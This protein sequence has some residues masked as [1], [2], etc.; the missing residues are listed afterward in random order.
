MVSLVA[1]AAAIGSSA[2][3]QQ[4][5]PPSSAAQTIEEVVVTAQKRSENVQN[6]PIAITAFTAQA[7]KEK[8]VQ[9]VHDL[10]ALTP[11]VNLD[12]SSPFSGSSVVLSASI[13]GIGQDDFAM[14]LDPGV[15]VYLDGVYLA[16]TVGA[17][18][19]LPDVE[20][21]EIA[22]G[23]QGTLFGRNTIGGAIS[24][25][26]HAPSDHYAFNGSATF[27]SYNRRDFQGIVD[28]PVNDSLRT[29]FTFSSE[30]RDGWQHVI[31]YPGLSG[32]RSDGNL[33]KSAGSQTS[34]TNGGQNQ[35]SI[36]G[37][38]LWLASD[39]LTVTLTADWTHVDQ[40]ATPNTALSTTE[41]V[42]GTLANLYDTCV[43]L[44]S[45]FLAGIGLGHVCNEPVANSG[46]IFSD[47]THPAYNSTIAGVGLPIDKTYANGNSF[48]KMD[49]YGGSLTI[50][51][52]LGENLNLKSIT[53]YRGLN[54]KAGLDDDGSP[55]SIIE[56]SFKE[57]QRQI[58]QEEQLTGE[59]FDGRLKYVG[60]LYYFNEHGYIHD[61]VVFDEGLLQINGP[62]T[63]DSSSYAAYT[64]MDYRLTD[65]IGLTLGA[66]YSLEEKEFI[67]GQ[68]DENGLAYKASG[69]Y[70]PG[71]SAAL[72]G[73]PANLTCQEAL[74]FPV[75]GQPLRYFPNT[76]N[77][78]DFRIF[79][80]AAGIQ[81]HFDGDRMAYF[82]YSKG[83]KSG[84]WTTRLSSPIPDASLAA[85]GPENA[86][87]Y[88]IGLKSKWLDRRLL[89]N[90][91]AFYTDYT[92]IQ[93]NFQQGISPT[94]KNA[95][96]AQIPGF[97]AETRWILGHGFSIG[98]SVGY[99]DAKYTKLAAGINGT[100]NCAIEACIDT[101][102]KL[103]K[104]PKWK[105]S[106]NPEYSYP[107]A[108]DASLRLGLDWNHTSSIF[109]NSVNSPI[110]RRPTVDVI[111]LQ[112]SYVAPGGR[113]EFTV[114]G[115]NITDQRYLV[116]GNCNTTGG[117]CS[118]TYNDPGEWYLRVRYRFDS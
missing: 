94:L 52:R 45:T 47:G 16:R 104:T 51:Y 20:R 107:L 11:N 118:G 43:S 15:G 80:P 115:T 28:I 73:A 30:Q 24:V 67:G 71:A 32:Y 63:L 83:F 70:P 103:P 89:L 54:W 50:D 66:R 74:G 25:V 106:L 5:P 109:N 62:N 113:Y 14:N 46:S 18:L 31:P 93:L 68:T 22:K 34:A 1:L 69:C 27:G 40:S 77:H 29:S 108:N 96:E 57:G 97:E 9:N 3:A 98:G 90:L 17:N 8:G 100:L 60:G 76:D 56:L 101:G 102:S 112:A 111:N 33:F 84:G 78:Q 35:Q 91:A 72:I 37:K 38:A 41:G 12:A 23:P 48:S 4:T 55:L 95:G 10:S 44:P 53:G 117:G 75:T 59:A 86:E 64:H 81:Y 61:F 82:S 114:G 92:G 110:L 79:T 88:E 7:L 105:F 19:D 26:T 87:T 21:I 42:P 116:T 58:S 65:K 2:A 99:M 13:R 49:A 85:F 6:V 39:R 36:R